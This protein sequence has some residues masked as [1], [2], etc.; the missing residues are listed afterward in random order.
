MKKFSLIL[1]SLAGKHS[2]GTTFSDFLELSICALSNQK[3]EER[4]LEIISRY[5][6]D[7]ALIFS[8]AFASM[9]I[10]M[11]D[12][13]NGWQD[14][15]GAYFEEFITRGHNGQFFTP[16]TITD[17]M[18]QINLDKDSSGQ[19]IIDPACGSGRTL[20]SAAKH[21]GPNNYFFA[22]DVDRNCAMM[23]AINLCL[24]GLKGEVAWMNS[25]SNQFFGGWI[26]TLFPFPHLIEINVDQSNIALKLPE[27]INQ[28]SEK[29]EFKPIERSNSDNTVQL[30]LF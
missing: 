26:I 15:L 6:K 19:R 9:I 10:E 5:S 3:K 23:S 13:Y 18:A 28:M 22:A 12:M 20:L 25:L 1:N 16:N 21:A 8:E 2:L 7:E 29:K 17:F 4:Y 11:G 24:H 14:P 30:S 27:F